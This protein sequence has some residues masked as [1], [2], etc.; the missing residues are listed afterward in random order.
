MAMWALNLCQL[1]VADLVVWLALSMLSACLHVVHSGTH[2]H[3]LYMF[4]PFRTV[5]QTTVVGVAALCAS[6]A[7]TFWT[8]CGR[9]CFEC[10]GWY[11]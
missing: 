1:A 10:M 3:R 9:N 6:S 7:A 8:I 11:I 4:K 2:L 5:Y